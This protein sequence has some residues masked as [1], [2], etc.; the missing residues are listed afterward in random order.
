MDLHMSLKN[1]VKIY[2]GDCVSIQKDEMFS[3]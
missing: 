1:G 2:I 3:Q